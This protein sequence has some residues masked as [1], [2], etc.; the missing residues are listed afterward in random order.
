MKKLFLLFILFLCKGLVNAQGTFQIKAG[1]TLTTAGSGTGIVLDNL[2]LVNNGT[3]LQTSTNNTV[4]FTGSANVKI[5][6][7]SSTLDKL[8]LAKGSGSNLNLQTDLFVLTE[9][10]FQGGLLNLGANTINLGSTG[11]L[12][13]ESEASRAFTTGQG[14][15][16]ATRTLNAPSVVNP[17]NL[18]AVISSPANLGTTVI[19]RGHAVQ[20]VANNRN[21]VKRYYDIDFANSI[22][23]NSASKS[24]LRFYYFNAELN[25]LAESQL[26]IWRRISKDNW[27]QIG[28]KSRDATANYVQGNILKNQSRWTIASGSGNIQSVQAAE[29]DVITGESVLLTATAIPNP[30]SSYFTLRT[31]SIRNEP[32][33]ILVTD[34]LG[35]TI[36]SKVNLQPNSTLQIGQHYNSGVYFVRVMQGKE[37][38]FIKL[39]KQAN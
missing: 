12:V 21:S 1:T 28:S 22:S 29:N 8:V 30:S 3:L 38:I 19:K 34:I 6:G 37:S 9:V 14:Y 25:G 26:V 24:T 32:V 11:L 39:V 35:R 16:Q 15:I 33:S 13:N 4:K 27:S 20:K 5:S 10:N 2:H 7:N 18:G 36:E 31:S 23:D 17:G